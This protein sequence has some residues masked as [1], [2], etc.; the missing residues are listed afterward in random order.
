MA[1]RIGFVGVGGMAETHLKH[2]RDNANA[3]I[4]SVCDVMEER[5]AKAAGAYDAT[6]YTNYKT[7]LEKESLD[8]LFVCVPP[9]A[10]ADIEETAASRGIHLFVEKPVGLDV[11]EARAKAE[12]IRR[13]GIVTSSGYALRYIGTAEMAK[14]YLRDKTIGMVRG[15]YLSGF[16]ETPWWRVMAKSG[17]QLVEQAT[18]V[19]DF[20]RYFAGD[21]STVYAN[22]ATRHLGEKPGLDIPD[23]TTVALRFESGAVGHLDTCCIQPDHRFG[24][25][26]QGHD[27]RVA[28]EGTK[29]TI[30]ERGNTETFENDVADIFKAQ[31]D[32]FIQ[33]ILANDPGLVRSSYADAL[34]SLELTVAANVSAGTGR[35]VSPAEL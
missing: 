26:I 11:R 1:L 22:M 35:A 33:A 27:F 18:H 32:T 10:H 5:A 20:M 13:A 12:A 3:R 7:M 6:P 15:H 8:A 19:A 4:V 16:V 28:Y 21:A 2:M 30:V 34:K 17:G 24:V 29:L 25:E 31:D 14:T 23:V 9:F